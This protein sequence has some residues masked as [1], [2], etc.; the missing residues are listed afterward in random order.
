MLCHH[1]GL[2]LPAH[3][4][5]LEHGIRFCLAIPS[6]QSSVPPTEFCVIFEQCWLEGYAFTQGGL[7]APSFLLIFVVERTV[8]PV[9]GLGLLSWPGENFIHFI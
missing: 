3:A 7:I 2:L 6:A 8:G 5:F 1:Q 4:I 9:R